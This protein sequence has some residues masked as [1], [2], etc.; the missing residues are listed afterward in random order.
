MENRRK[1]MKAVEKTEGD[2]G[3]D[4]EKKSD[5]KENHQKPLKP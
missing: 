3:L 1:P 2:I 5:F 4:P